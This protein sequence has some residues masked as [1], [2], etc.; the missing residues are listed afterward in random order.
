MTIPNPL[1]DRTY[2]LQDLREGVEDPQLILNELQNNVEA[3]KQ[4]SEKYKNSYTF[5]LKYGKGVDFVSEDWDTMILLDACRLD[6]FEDRHTFEDGHLESRISRGSN[7]WMFVKE[8]FGGNNST[9]RYT[10]PQTH[11]QQSST[12]RRSTLRYSYTTSGTPRSGQ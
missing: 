4:I 2:D 6:T 3:V 5:R 1:I 8:N 7:S 9:T 11:G 12:K 10:C